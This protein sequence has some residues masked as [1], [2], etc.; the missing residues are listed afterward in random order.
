MPSLKLAAWSW[1]LP[2]SHR[3]EHYPTGCSLLALLCHAPREEEPPFTNGRFDVCN[4]E[5][6]RVREG[7]MVSTRPC[8]WKPMA[9][10][11]TYLVV[12]R[13]K[14]GKVFRSECPRHT[15]VQ[16]GLNH[17]GLQHSNILAKG[18]GR[19]IIQ[20]LAEA[21]EACS[22][23]TGIRR[24]ILGQMSACSWIMS[25]RYKTWVV[26]LYLWPTA[27][28]TSGGARVAWSGVCRNIVS[29]FFPTRRG[30]LLRRQSRCLSSFSRAL[31]AKPRQFLLRHRRA[32]RPMQRF[33]RTSTSPASSLFELLQHH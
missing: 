33:A 17:L 15:P 26:C 11:R 2:T 25:P 7:D 6:L 24:S 27:S 29:A 4:R 13:S 30:F 32:T 12:S 8:R 3:P 5:G 19:P 1:A 28:M 9:R 16:Q 21:F 22:H 20:L 10:N 23:K 31:Q 18:G 14:L